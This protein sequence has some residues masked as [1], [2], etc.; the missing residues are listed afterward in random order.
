MKKK[1]PRPQSTGKN[2]WNYKHGKCTTEE[3]QR[4]ADFNCRL[5]FLYD[6]AIHGGFMSNPSKLLGR[7]PKDYFKP[8]FNNMWHRVYVHIKINDLDK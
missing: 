4:R 6:M 2:H 3:R 1:F 8:D 5:R 7:T